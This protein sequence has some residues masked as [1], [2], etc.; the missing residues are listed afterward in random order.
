MK[1]YL[2]SFTA[3]LFLLAAGLCAQ[4]SAPAE[5]GQP[6]PAW[7]E[8]MLDI[9][10]I[11][12]GRGDSI[13][14]ILPDGTTLLVDVGDG[15]ANPLAAP[16]GMP[17]KPD[18]SRQAGEW[19]AR[20]IL[21]ALR[22]FPEKK[23]DY[24]IISHFHGDHLG[25][26]HAGNKRSAEGD[27]RLTGISE[28]P[29]FIPIRTIID[30]DW[31]DYN[32]PAPPTSEHYRNYRQFLDWQVKRRSLAVER[33]KP[34]QNDQLVLRHDAATYPTFEIR[35]LIANGRVWT[36]QGTDTRE[37]ANVKN[38][39]RLDE[40][41]CS[42]GFRI[43]YGKFDYFSGGDLDATANVLM[44]GSESWQDVE[45]AAAK[46][47]GPIDAMKANHHGSWNANSAEF[48]SLLRP[49]VIVVTSRADGHP[50]VNTYKRM[51]SKSLWPGPRD[52]FITNVTP[53]TQA[54]TYNVDKAQSQ[55][56]HVVIRVDSGG[57]TYRVYVLD[58]SDEEQRVKAVFGPYRSS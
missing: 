50:A 27:Y 13:F 25:E 31:P 9:H 52:I 48:L 19:I 12:T 58:D 43:T 36:G 4:P 57:A 35:N 38:G 20:Y 29:E 54:T 45:P 10:H 18:N 32:Y 55:Q 8:G 21:R 28:I 53:A 40:N 49:R 15:Q 23:I 41:Q 24:A 14:H 11:N 44:P 34:G 16:F 37:L 26:V 7:S 46:A 39:E 2:L 1:T 6:L 17:T 51:T 33:F 56:G 3:G 5:V 42:I 30:R 22:S 47:S